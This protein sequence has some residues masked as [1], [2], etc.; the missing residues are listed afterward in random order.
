MVQVPPGGFFARTCIRHG[1]GQKSFDDVADHLDSVGASLMDDGISDEQLTA[2][3]GG[4]FPNLTVII[5]NVLNGDIM[6]EFVQDVTWG[7][8]LESADRDLGIHFTW[9]HLERGGHDTDR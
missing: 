4:R 6:D 3:E 7:R 9:L 8:R 1:D 2:S 5:I